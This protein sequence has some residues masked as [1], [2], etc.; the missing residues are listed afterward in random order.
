[1]E[2][3][4]KK[5]KVQ[6]EALFSWIKANKIGTC[7]I[8]TGLGKTFIAFHALYTMPKN[9][10]LHLF[11]AETKEREK[12]MLEQIQK[13]NKIFGRDV[14]RDYN[15][16][17]YCYQ[18]ARNWKNKEFGLVIGDEIHDS[19]TLQN[20]KFYLRNKYD[21]LIGL[22]ATIEVNTRYELSNGKFITKGEMLNRIAPICFKYNTEDSIKNKTS[23]KLN[24]YII[25]TK[26][27]DKLKTVKSG[28]KKKIFY[29]TERKA[30]DYWNKT[31]SKSLYLPEE[32][33]E[34]KDKKD[35][36]IGGAAKRR[37]DI[38]YQLIDKI[39]V[40]KDLLHQINGKTIIFGNHIDTL[41][42]I[43]PNVVSSRNSDAKNLKI[44][45]NFNKGYLNVIG[46]FKKLKQGANL[47]GLD[48]CIII[49]YYGV[50]KDMVQRVGRLRDNGKIGNVFILL[51]PNTQEEIWFSKMSTSLNEYNMIYCKNIQECLKYLKN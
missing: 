6:K 33:Q 41:L 3:I 43:T 11:L 14:L 37:S 7:E 24:I 10:K 39:K 17:F 15:L 42:K 18:T 27:E 30:Y 13:Y 28:N 23:R 47:D 36:I 29:Q 26:L 5:D 12:D 20:G 25:E 40:T 2:S 8:V 35:R 44:R 19:L 38:L 4:E 22:S 51:T 21:A 16:K 49:S 1:M 34:Q 31:F 50:E 32:T 45:D 46:S 48:N 9:K